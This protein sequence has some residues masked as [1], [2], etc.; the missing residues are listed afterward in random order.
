MNDNSNQK[1]RAHNTVVGI[2]TIACLGTIAGSISLGWE[3][4]VP[5]LIVC[6]MVAAWFMHFT[7]YGSWTFRENYYLILSMFLSFYHGVH[8][9]STFEIV[10]VSA[11]VM[12]NVTLFKR[13]EFITIMLVECIC[14]FVL[15]MIMGFRTGMLTPD[16]LTVSKLTLHILCEFCIYK[17]LYD[18]IKN[19]R[20]DSG[21]LEL[22]N[23]EKETERA[24]LEDFLVNIS[25]ELRT[26]VNVVNGMSS[27]ILKKENRDDI[28]TIRDA[29]LRLSRQIEDIQD[30]S[31]IQRGE[32]IL[33][34]DKYMITSLL[35]DIIT[36]FE[37]TEEKNDLDLVIDL[38]PCVPA[39]L[40]GDSGKINKVIWHLLDNAVK[41]TKKG[42]IFLKVT[43]IKREYG[44]NL[45]IE[46]KDTGVGI[47]ASDMDRISKGLYR[48]D[49]GRSRRA[50]GIGLGFS[51]IYGFV[52]AMNG[53]VNI[54]GKKGEGTTVRISI[55]QE[56]IDPSPCMSIGDSSKYSVAFFVFPRKYKV[57]QLMHFYRDMA[58]DMASGLNINLYSAS[59][60]AELKRLVENGDITHVFMGEEEYMGSREY[61]NGL[62]EQGIK[63]AVS[64]GTGFAPA[65]GSGVI[66]LSKPLYGCPVMKVLN[67]EATPVIQAGSEASRKPALDGVRA[68]VVDDEPMN[69]IVA[70]GLLKG[71][72][73]II[74][75]AKSGRESILKFAENDYDIVFMDHMMPEMD[76]I[77]AM[78]HL[79]DSAAQKGR[80]ICI[81]ALT[82]NAVSGAKEMFLREGFDGFISKPINI[83]DFD[84]TINRLM[85]MIIPG[86]K[87]GLS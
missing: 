63:V 2:M 72:N 18:A 25:H 13:K 53:F 21:E 79:R 41:F 67:G 27:M 78:R 76:G 3:F 87:G 31:E 10:V 55:A 81:V 39:M 73:M 20:M 65:E 36:N 16:I 28:K 49:K 33:E 44:I 47:S 83:N 23:K 70:T 29:G 32:V 59:S 37:V 84:R 24:Q 5:P 54:S 52:R 14:L 68:L 61:L 9:T 38:D 64:A 30:Y 51:I 60:L 86:K 50:S 40:K 80:N 8:L 35:N 42:G 66:V 69:L 17:G 77:E 57:A 62:A 58:S 11:L 71:Y 19:N 26:P 85:P 75:T 34:E 45:V 15:Q 82:A 43:S 6:G 56:V 46:V 22:R 7:Q 4:W 74:D 48:G 12:V 1:A